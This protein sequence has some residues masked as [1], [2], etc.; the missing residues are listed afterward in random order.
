M[1]RSA[2]LALTWVTAALLAGC[3]HTASGER[4]DR[5]AWEREVTRRGVDLE[6]AVFP[7]ATTP[8]MERWVEEVLGRHAG[9]GGLRKLTRPPGRRC[10][11]RHFGFATTPGLTLTAAEA[12][13]SRRG[14]CLSFTSMFVAMARSAGIPAFLMSV[15]REP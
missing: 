4:L 8:E 11:A 9:D 6:A 14:N 15:R 2:G 7:F 1:R 3:S 10:S 12:F 13:A 5:A